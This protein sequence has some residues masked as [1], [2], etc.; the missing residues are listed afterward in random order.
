MVNFCPRISTSRAFFMDPTGLNRRVANSQTGQLSC[1]IFPLTRPAHA[2]IGEFGLSNDA[3]RF[4]FVVVFFQW[5]LFRFLCAHGWQATGRS[6]LRVVRYCGE[7]WFNS[8]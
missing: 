3:T 4:L 6:S 1:P 5:L 7:P 8:L 2:R